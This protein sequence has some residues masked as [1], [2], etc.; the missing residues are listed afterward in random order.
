[1]TPAHRL[2]SARLDR[3]EDAVPVDLD[4]MFRN[5]DPPTGY[6]EL[7]GL[8]RPCAWEKG[9]VEFRWQVRPDL[10]TPWGAV[11]GG[12]L[13]ALADQAA[14]TAAVTVV[15]DGETFGT[16]DLRI[17]PMRAVREGEVRIEARVVHRSRSAIHCEVDFE[18][19]D[20]A[21]VAKAQA[22]QVLSRGSA[23]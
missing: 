7:L 21:I 23:D 6:A 14:G 10:L 15:E 18:T 5:E 1:M 19:E 11:F 20:G 12:Y 16:A 9:R 2:D 8:P 22:I 3:V 4:A 13:A 17:S